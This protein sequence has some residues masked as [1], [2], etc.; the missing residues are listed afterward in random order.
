MIKAALR[1]L[2]LER[3]RALPPREQLLY[4]GG[5]AALLLVLYLSIWLP[6]QHD[7]ARLRVAVPKEKIQYAQM[8]VQAMEMNQLRASG[9]RPLAGG[10][11]LANLEQSA[12]A[13]GLRGRISR[14]EPDGVNGAR[15]SLDAVDFNALISW[16]AN[17]QS[18]GGVRVEKATFEPLPA[19]GTINAKLTLR[20]AGA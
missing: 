5:A 7:L 2:S 4:L 11:L 12:T 3:L 19:P 1:N 18:Q 14:M 13:S 9:R 8:Q 6:I 17:L 16:L 10:N 20:G 15:L